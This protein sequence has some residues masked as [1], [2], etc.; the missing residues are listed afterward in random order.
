M[1]L[2]SV[3][4]CLNP[5]DSIVYV[6]S[7]LAT[8]NSRE[9]LQKKLDLIRTAG[10]TKKTVSQ[11]K[12]TD[13]RCGFQPLTGDN[14]MMGDSQLFSW[15]CSIAMTDREANVVSSDDGKTAVASELSSK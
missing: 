10:I 6:N 9:T 15:F 11:L 13:L 12:F 2:F 14:F 4:T 7:L 5:L 3:S 1:V 8:L